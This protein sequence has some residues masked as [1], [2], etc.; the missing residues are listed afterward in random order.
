VLVE[1]KSRQAQVCSNPW[2][3]YAVHR[4]PPEAAGNEFGDEKAFGPRWQGVPVDVL[5]HAVVLDPV[6]LART[7][8]RRDAGERR[9]WIHSAGVR[10]PIENVGDKPGRML[11]GLNTGIY[12]AIDLS[13]WIAGNPAD[14]HQFWAA[15]GIVWEVP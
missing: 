5:D 15:T 14:V 11:I 10:A 7:V 12:E 2:Y 6:R 3:L 8:P 9:C 1:F 4:E 13:Q